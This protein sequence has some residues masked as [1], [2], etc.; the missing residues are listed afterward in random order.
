MTLLF[1]MVLSQAQ[2]LVPRPQNLKYETNI[3]QPL[4]QRK[5][6]LRSSL[7]YIY[8]P[9]DS[10]FNSKGR[11]TKL[12]SN[13]FIEE[14]RSGI[15]GYDVS[16]LFTLEY[17]ITNRFGI[18]LGLPYVTSESIWLEQREYVI[19][20]SLAN[21]TKYNDSKGISDLAI[22]LRYQFIEKNDFFA[23]GAI[24]AWIP[25]GKPFEDT[26]TTEPLEIKEHSSMNRDKPIVSAVLWAK[27]IYYPYAFEI[28]ADYIYRFENDRDN[29][30]SNYSLS[31]QWGLLL[32]S[33][34]SINNIWEYRYMP[35]ITYKKTAEYQEFTGSKSYQLTSGISTVQQV[36]QFRFREQID[37][38]IVGRNLP[39]NMSLMFS[40]YYTL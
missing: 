31:G 25:V 17:G 14:N 13:D 40:I 20:D 38:P 32:N 29:A 26:I 39:T 4:N 11:R 19:I 36:K 8:S 3:T 7:S 12:Y 15:S 24:G 9:F 2:E 23:V 34:F 5:G 37:F 6:F 33:W 16:Y 27:K 22:F 35:S 1:V 10:Y 28:R 18:E 21:E 30:S